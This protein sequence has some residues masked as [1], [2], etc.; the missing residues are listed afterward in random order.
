MAGV[1][2]WVEGS[3]VGEESGGAGVVRVGEGRRERSCEC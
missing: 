1:E 3:G 2:E